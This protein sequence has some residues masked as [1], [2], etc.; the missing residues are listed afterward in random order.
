M[1]LFR[2]TAEILR[3]SLEESGSNEVLVLNLLKEHGLVEQ[4]YGPGG[5]EALLDH[6]FRS[7][8]EPGQSGVEKAEHFVRITCGNVEALGD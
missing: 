7:S 6:M 8:G 2:E 4:V 5:L 1:T 3:H